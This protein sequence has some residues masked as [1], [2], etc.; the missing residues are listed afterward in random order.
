MSSPK[1][2]LADGEAALRRLLVN[3]AQQAPDLNE[4]DTR[5]R[6]IDCLIHDCL[7]WDR[8]SDL[9]LERH[10]NGEYS[11]YELGTPPLVVIEAKRAGQTFEVPSEGTKSVLR[12][13]RSLMSNSPEFKLAFVQA[14]NYCSE[15]GI[16][17]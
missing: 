17:I 12:S 7:G 4:A 9:T 6:F 11:D 1:H 16:Q 2:T 3:M 13:I 14:A 8:F 15:R 10:F 5:H